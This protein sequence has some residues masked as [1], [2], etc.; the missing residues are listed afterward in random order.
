MREQEVHTFFIETA[1]L[2][3]EIEVNYS[4]FVDHAHNKF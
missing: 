1:P 2:L 3:F 4:I